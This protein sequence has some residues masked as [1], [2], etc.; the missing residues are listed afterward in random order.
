MRIVH[1]V[2]VHPDSDRA[3]IIDGRLFFDQTSIDRGLRC[4]EMCANADTPRRSVPL[5]KER[6]SWHKG[7]LSVDS[8][9]GKSETGNACALENY[10]K[11]CLWRCLQGGC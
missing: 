8:L 6:E 10:T 4:M 11:M 1:S 9:Q 2:T 3:D 5:R 7:R